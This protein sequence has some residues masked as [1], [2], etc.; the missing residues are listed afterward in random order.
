[1]VERSSSDSEEKEGG[2]EKDVTA[3]LAKKCGFGGI[4]LAFSPGKPVSKVRLA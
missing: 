1:M 3:G 2:N 4:L